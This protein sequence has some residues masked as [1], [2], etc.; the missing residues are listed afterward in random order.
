M[1]GLWDLPVIFI[2]ENNHYGARI[3]PLVFQC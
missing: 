1:A 3:A 2:C